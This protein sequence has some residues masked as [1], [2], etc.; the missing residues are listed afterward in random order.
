MKKEQSKGARCSS[1]LRSDSR[2]AAESGG[3]WVAAAG[4]SGPE[5]V[6]LSGE[7]FGGPLGLAR[8]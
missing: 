3:A 7:S 8:G 6:E 1:T 2:E 4:A 5:V